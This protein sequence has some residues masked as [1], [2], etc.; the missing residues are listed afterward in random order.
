MEIDGDY[1]VLKA[2][3]VFPQADQEKLSYKP[4]NFSL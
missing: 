2:D 4:F 1:E 3:Q